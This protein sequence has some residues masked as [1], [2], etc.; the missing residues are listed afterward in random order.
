MVL[1]EISAAVVSRTRFVQPF[2]H[3]NECCSA[4]ALDDG[5]GIRHIPRALVASTI[6]NQSSVKK[7]LHV[8]PR[9]R[10]PAGSSIFRTARKPSRS[11]SPCCSAILPRSPTTPPRRRRRRPSSSTVLRATCAARPRPP[12]PRVSESLPSYGPGV[13]VAG[14]ENHRPCACRGDP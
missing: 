7:T 5:G 3:N 9:F 10:P 12:P 8:S 11:F 6:S 14:G 13:D 1:S 4:A 2:P